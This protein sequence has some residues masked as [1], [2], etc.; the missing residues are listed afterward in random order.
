[1]QMFEAP[2]FPHTLPTNKQH[3]SGMGPRVDQVIPGLNVSFLTQGHMPLS[4]F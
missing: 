2:I 4:F 1:M 3:K